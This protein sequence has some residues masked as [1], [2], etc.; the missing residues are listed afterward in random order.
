MIKDGW[1]TYNFNNLSCNRKSRYYTA[2]ALSDFADFL[3]F[4]DYF[5]I[6]A[7]VNKRYG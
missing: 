7:S 1:F 5:N 6:F 2:M 3:D 4:S